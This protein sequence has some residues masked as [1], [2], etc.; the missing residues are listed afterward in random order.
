MHIIALIWIAIILGVMPLQAI[1]S[2]RKVQTLQPTRMQAYTSTISGLLSMGAITLLIDWFSGRSGLRAV[3]PMPDALKLAAWTAGT[4]LAC[5][6]VWF[7][8]M[9]QRKLWQQSPDEVVALLLPQTARERAAFM[10]VSLVAG[11]MEEY[12]MRG[13]CLLVLAHATGSMTLSFILVTLGFAVAHGY[14]GAWALLRT[15]MLGALLA[16]PVIITGSL[17]PSM[18]AHAGTDIL[19]G[20]FG[21]RLLHRWGLVNPDSPAGSC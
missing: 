2:R 20:F 9:L 4:C 1:W 15:G 21:Y 3:R 13:F 5:A 17:L 19:A 8:G 16:V 14:Q 18:I 11:T 10:A 12:V 7:A 6:V